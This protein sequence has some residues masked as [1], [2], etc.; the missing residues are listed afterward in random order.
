[1]NITMKQLCLIF[2]VIL[3]PT[4]GSA[5]YLGD[6]IVVY[7]DNRVEIKISTP[8]FDQL[9]SD[10]S[11]SYALKEFQG[12]LPEI[13]DQLN[14]EKPDLVKY[15][16][17]EKLII[18]PGNS[19]Y[20]YL[21]KNGVLSNTGYRDHAIIIL[22]DYKIFITTSNLSKISDI[23]LSSCLEKTFQKLPSKSN[24]SKNLYYECID[25]NIKALEDLTTNNKQLDFL[26]FNAGVGA[27]LIKSDWVAD[28]AFGI[29]VGFNRKGVLKH[30]PYVSANM[31]FDFTEE[32]AIRINT[33]LNLGYKWNTNKKSEKREMLGFELGYL[34]VQQGDLFGEN[35]FKLGANWSPVSGI[36]V[37]PQLYFT[38][39]FKTIYPAVRIGIG[40]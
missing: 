12:L 4:L 27:G 19:E 35:T 13:S 18:E 7:V 40:F 3:L 15:T 26:E 16:T 28:L 22:D 23:S 8:D 39:N 33:F 31:V 9:R 6:T 21:F 17:G 2:T 11:I 1:M 25:E 37:S 10:Q 38:D 24:W 34:I 29:G 30:N 14:G 5:Q 20:I 32:Q 36:T